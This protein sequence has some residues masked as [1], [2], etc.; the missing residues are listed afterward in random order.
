MSF[1]KS[2]FS[3]KMQ[4]ATVIEHLIETL[5][6]K[7]DHCEWVQVLHFEQLQDYMNQNAAH[8]VLSGDPYPN[9]SVV[10]H[11]WVGAN[12]YDVRVS[13]ADGSRGVLITSK[14]AG[15]DDY[16][17]IIEARAQAARDSKAADDMVIRALA[18][19]IQKERPVIVQ[20]LSGKALK[21]F[22]DT[23]S[24]TGTPDWIANDTVLFGAAICRI[25]GHG[26]CLTM[27][28]QS[29]TRA[30]VSASEIPSDLITPDKI[31]EAQVSLRGIGSN[32]GEKLRE[33][34]TL[35]IEF[36]DLPQD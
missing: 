28:G 2:L 7:D 4:R 6:R 18:L 3:P 33:L 29:S 27:F 26:T 25:S 32:W 22:I 14:F 30:Y 12:D 5:A 16:S 20:P 35:D 31:A 21:R 34:D 13:R 23:H 19:S 36:D 11:V 8:V 15:T 9:E 10:Y 24:L 17:E 1:L